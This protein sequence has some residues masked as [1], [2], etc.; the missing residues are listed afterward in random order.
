MSHSELYDVLGVSPEAT[1]GQIKKAYLKLAKQYHPDKN[2]DGRFADKFKE[3]SA[4]YEVLGDEEK[5]QLYDQYGE[6]GVA[7]GGPPHGHG[8]GDPFG[9]IFD[10]LGGGGPR[11][12]GPRRGEDMAYKLGIT[13]KEFYN[14]KTT[15]LRATRNV[16]CGKCQGSGSKKPGVEATCKTCSGRG[17]RIIVRQIGPGMMQRMEAAC[18][19]CGG[20]GETIA[21]KDK[22]MKC[23]AKKVNAEEIELEVNVDRGM[24]SGQK[25]TFRGKANQ[26]PGVTPGDIVI[27]LQEKQ[28]P[29]CKFVRKGDDLVYQHELTLSEALTGYRFPITQLDGRTLI[30]ESE[31]GD[32]VKPGDIRVIEDEGFPKHKNPCLKGNLYIRFKLVFPDSDDLKDEDVRKK[33][34]EL[35]PPKPDY[36]V[37]EDDETEE[38]VA[39]PFREGIDEIGRKDFSGRD[40]TASDDEDQMEGRGGCVHQ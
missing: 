17:V 3:V 14:G 37:E 2:P 25:V 20:R 24:K 31:E 23:K 12:R 6:E 16:I 28:D 8:G 39:K 7:A 18:N 32:I 4:A 5:R 11:Q 38:C 30:I 27:I 19:D 33:L 34:V 10:L 26:E 35:L 36:D 13:L 1:P 40:A 22:C 9:S 21:E 29:S 15:K